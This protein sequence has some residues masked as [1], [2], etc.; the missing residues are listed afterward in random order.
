MKYCVF[1]D[2]VYHDKDLVWEKGKWYP[3]TF[4]DQQSYCFDGRY[5]VSKKLK[6]KMYFVV[7]DRKEQ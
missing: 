5:A 1:N 3:I 4:E 6:D 2:D 7:E